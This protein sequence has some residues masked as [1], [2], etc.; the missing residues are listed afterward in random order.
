MWQNVQT[1]VKTTQQIVKSVRSGR[2]SSIRV[3]KGFL[4]IKT[5]TKISQIL[6]WIFNGGKL[7][8]KY[9]IHAAQYSPIYPQHAHLP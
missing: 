7:T 1:A 4:E 3:L 9:I 5:K 2:L 6:R 8:I